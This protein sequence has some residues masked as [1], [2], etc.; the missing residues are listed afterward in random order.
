MNGPL[1]GRLLPDGLV[2]FINWV[3]ALRMVFPVK[4]Y[5]TSPTGRFTNTHRTILGMDLHVL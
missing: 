2:Q 1:Y 4:Y 3:T 5:H